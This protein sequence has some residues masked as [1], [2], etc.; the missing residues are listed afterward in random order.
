MNRM[1]LVGGLI[2]IA[3]TFIGSC[4][5]DS[6][7]CLQ[8][9]PCEPGRFSPIKILIAVAEVEASRTDSIIAYSI[10]KGL[11]PEGSEIE[12]VSLVDSIPPLDELIQF[13]AILLYT[14]ALLAFPDVNDSIGNTM[15]DYV[16]SGGGIVMCQWSMHG[17]GA[18][19]GGRL[20]SPGY[21]PF[22]PGLIGNINDD[23]RIEISSIDFPLHPVFY[24]IDVM[25]IT[26]PGWMNIPHPILDESATLL[27]KDQFDA[28][29]IAINSTG[30]IIGLNIWP[31]Y[32]FSC[33][34]RYQNAAML[35]ANSLMFVA[36]SLK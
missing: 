13:D 10:E 32:V 15:A 28:N 22:K 26:S 25:N 20:R 31:S 17:G 30:N 27:A 4:S 18:G 16:D 33:H 1:I 11:F 35:I 36:G 3:F 7:N 34:D 14:V 24:E 23:R 9:P 21:S 8:C 2:A 29:A 5:E 19:I 6:D 12:A